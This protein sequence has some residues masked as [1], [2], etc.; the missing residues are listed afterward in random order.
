MSGRAVLFSQ[1]QFKVASFQDW[2]ATA[3]VAVSVKRKSRR[4]GLLEERKRHE[5]RNTT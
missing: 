1:G 3:V 2:W 4:R 5:T